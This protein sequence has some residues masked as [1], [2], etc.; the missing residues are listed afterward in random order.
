MKFHPDLT[1]EQWQSYSIEFQM[2]NIGS[3]VERAMKWKAKEKPDLANQANNRCLELFDLTI[4]DPQHLNYL[5]EITR[6]RELWL[7]FFIGSN[8]YQQT[9]LMWQKYFRPFAVLANQHD[10]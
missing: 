5:Q 9:N 8:Q 2:A 6:A 7:D 10:N 3:E 1:R 4:S